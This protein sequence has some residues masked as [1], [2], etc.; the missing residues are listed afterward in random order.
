MVVAS[1]VIARRRFACRCKATRAVA[2]LLGFEYE[3]A[4]FVEVYAPRVGRAV[5]VVEG[6]VALEDV[7]VFRVIAARGFGTRDAD[8][9]TQFAQE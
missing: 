4:A 8:Y 9:V 5:G 2:A 1:R 3:R 6:D 7:G